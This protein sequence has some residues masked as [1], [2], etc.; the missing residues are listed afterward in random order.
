MA[1]GTD[2]ET[3]LPSERFVTG[4]DAVARYLHDEAEWAPHGMPIA[5]VC[6]ESTAEAQAVVAYARTHGHPLVPRGA[7][8]AW[9]VTSDHPPRRAR[10]TTWL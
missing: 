8:H 5:V 3:V 1:L 2:L 4:R 7:A 10:H 6:P 9:H